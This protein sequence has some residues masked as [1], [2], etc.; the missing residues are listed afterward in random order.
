MIGVI[1]YGNRFPFFLMAC[2]KNKG[3][4][5]EKSKNKFYLNVNTMPI[6]YFENILK[7]YLEYT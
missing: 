6:I 2:K 7:I 5:V 1:L 4:L 3:Q